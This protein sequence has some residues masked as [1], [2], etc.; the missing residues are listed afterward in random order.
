MP[1]IEPSDGRLTGKGQTMPHIEPDYI[2]AAL[3]Q[4]VYEVLP[5]D[6]SIYGEIPGFQGVYANA[7]TQEACASEL[8]EVLKEWLHIRLS[9][10]RPVPTI[11]GVKL[12]TSYAAG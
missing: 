2:Q 3:S 8:A 5:D 12:T 1:H 11:P 9:R 10:G 6:G 7:A 4:A